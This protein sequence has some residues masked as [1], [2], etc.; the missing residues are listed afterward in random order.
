MGKMVANATGATFISLLGIPK[1]PLW[2][3]REDGLISHTFEH[4]I[5]TGDSTWL[6][7]LP[8]TK[9]VVKAMDAVGEYSRRE[10]MTPIRRFVILDAS[11]RGWTT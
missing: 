5:K 2:N 7:L 3:L 10:G 9:S 6:L 11:K 1:Q 4:Y 8:M